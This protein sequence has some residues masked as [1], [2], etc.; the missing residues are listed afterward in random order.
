MKNHNSPYYR[1]GCSKPTLFLPKLPPEEHRFRVP[2]KIKA[3]NYYTIADGCKNVYKNSDAISD[4]GTSVIVDPCETSYMNLFINGVLQP[5]ENYTVEAGKITLN[6]EDIP[7]KG[8]PIVLQ[9]I[10]I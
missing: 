2:Q 10:T 9:M 4:V 7:I 5:Y 8:A 3:K 1:R 6:T